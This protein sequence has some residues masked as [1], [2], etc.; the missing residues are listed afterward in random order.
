MKN[1]EVKEGGSYWKLLTLWGG[2]QMPNN[3]C[4]LVWRTLFHSILIV[5]VVL[6]LK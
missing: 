6:L 1:I 2:E 3:G 4:S 5:F